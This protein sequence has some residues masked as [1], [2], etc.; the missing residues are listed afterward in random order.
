MKHK[1][2][3]IP[4]S[5]YLY[6]C[7]QLLKPGIID[8]NR[9]FVAWSHPMYNCTF[10]TLPIQNVFLRYG[11]I[12]E[13]YTSPKMVTA[14]KPIRA[15]RLVDWNL[16]ISYHSRRLLFNVLNSKLFLFSFCV[17]IIVHV[18]AKTTRPQDRLVC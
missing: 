5:H 15:G 8:W 6:N 16:I 10:N 2:E 13:Y 7:T 9:Q 3:F 11:A 1:T 12:F 17:C 18:I 4:F 14:T